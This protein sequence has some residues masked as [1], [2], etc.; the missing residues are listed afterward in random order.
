MKCGQGSWWEV[1]VICRTLAAC[2]RWQ[3]KARDCQSC[4]ASLELG[5][6]THKL[7]ASGSMLLEGGNSPTED[8]LLP[9]LLKCL[10]NAMRLMPPMLECD[11]LMHKEYRVTKKGLRTSHLVF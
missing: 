10:K 1:P 7:A 2:Q 8:W 11:N 6:S 3:F 4:Q 9:R 5:E